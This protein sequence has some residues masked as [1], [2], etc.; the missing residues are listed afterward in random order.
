MTLGLNR[1]LFT[2]LLS[3]T[4]YSSFSHAY[5]VIPQEFSSYDEET[6]DNYWF[7]LKPLFTKEDEHLQINGQ[8][9]PLEGYSE[10]ELLYLW[11]TP[12]VILDD[13]VV[14]TVT[15]TFVK[16]T[17][18]QFD[19][20]QKYPVGSTFGNDP[21]FHSVLTPYLSPMRNHLQWLAYEK[22]FY[23][24][25]IGLAFLHQSPKAIPG[26]QSYS[27]FVGAEAYSNWRIAKTDVGVTE[28]TFELGIQENLNN[29]GTDMGENVGSVVTN[30][31][32]HGDSGP[33]IG[34]IYLTQGLA[35][36]RFLMYGGR[37]TAWYFYGY[38][39]FVDSEVKRFNSSLVSG[40]AAIPVGGGNGSKPGV[41]M[42]YFVNDH[43]YFSSV[44]TNS[45]GED[46]GF[47]FNVF[48]SEA[49]FAG[50]ESG[51]AWQDAQGLKGRVSIGLHQARNETTG[52][53]YKTGE[54]INIT[55]KK[56]LSP[57]GFSPY[58][59]IFL[60]Y[61]YSDP[62]ITTV[63]EQVSAGVNINHPFHRRGDSF[64]LALGRLAP[65]SKI[66]DR[67]Y[68]MESYYRWQ[69]TENTKLSVNLQL[70]V[71]PSDPAQTEHL[72]PIY[73]GRLYFTF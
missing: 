9:L 24:Q 27:G 70:I 25:I 26:K 40:G 22:G 14:D 46:S 13:P 12:T 59:G 43:V 39:T 31:V 21:L 34:D 41:A 32:V 54:G 5:I 61:T 71:D 42:Q 63:E 38:N 17:V 15:E 55:F 53:G 2:F 56:E 37:L 33:I 64:G 35:D 23:S 73:G 48:D 45:E 1:P 19:R 58:A 62:D 49:Y 10:R 18:P 47:D 4:L 3:I 65:S 44:Y 69:F 6:P 68:F 20:E 52:N 51:F 30:N 60:Q 36:N 66:R 67:E 29:N 7:T 16:P 50:I 72:V 28:I 11:V 57:K 8:L